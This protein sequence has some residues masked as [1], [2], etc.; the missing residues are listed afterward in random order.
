MKEKIFSAAR[1]VIAFIDGELVSDTP[2]IETPG[3]F[4]MF[5]FTVTQKTRNASR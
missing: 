4:R 2:R 5:D 1:Y 3:D